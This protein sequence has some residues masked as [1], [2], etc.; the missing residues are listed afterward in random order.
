MAESFM[1]V[2]CRTPTWTSRGAGAAGTAMPRTPLTRIAW[3]ANQ[4]PDDTGI[5][6]AGGAPIEDATKAM[7]F[8]ELGRTPIYNTSSWQVLAD[9]FE[10]PKRQRIL[11]TPR[12]AE[13]KD[14]CLI[15]RSSPHF[16]GAHDPIAVLALLASEEII[17]L[18][19]PSGM[20]ISPTN[21][22]HLSLT[23]VHPFATR[24]EVAPVERTRWL[25]MKEKRAQGR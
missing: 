14:F 12:N 4:N 15:P 1:R 11:P 23:F 6:V 19:F 7:T 17:T 18:S 22:L 25:G 5:L 20:P 9:H 24:A 13:V 16:A 2:R 21:Q 10:S 3:C 8:F